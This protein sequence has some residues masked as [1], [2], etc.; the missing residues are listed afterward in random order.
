MAIWICAGLSE[1]TASNVS[2]LIMFHMF[3]LFAQNYTILCDQ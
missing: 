2:I 3:V 1:L